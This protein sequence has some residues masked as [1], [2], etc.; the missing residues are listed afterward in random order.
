MFRLK[1]SLTHAILICVLIGAAH[2]LVD[3]HLSGE[4]EARAESSLRRA[5]VIADQTKRTDH[6]A[7]MEKG[8]MVAQD[9][10][11]YDFL[12]LERKKLLKR[13]R[14]QYSFILS[15]DVG[16]KLGKDKEKTV[17]LKGDVGLSTKDLRHLT[18]DFRLRV[19]RKRFGNIQSEMSETAR[20][21]DLD[22]LKRRPVQP[23]MLM[24]LNSSGVAVAA[25]GKDLYH[26]GAS[27]YS[28][29]VTKDHPIVQKVLDNPGAG[30]RLDVWEWSWTSDGDKS[31]YQVAIV[32]IRPSDAKKP[33]GVVVVGYTIHDGAAEDIQRLVGGVTTKKGKQNQYVDKEQVESAPDVAFFRG[34][35]IHSST[36][37]SSRNQKLE[38][39][40]FK[41]KSL[42]EK[43]DRDPEKMVNF[44]VDGT[45]YAGFVRFLPE[46]DGAETRT[47][48]MV[49][50]NMEEV[51]APLAKVLRQFDM[52][53][54][55]VFLLPVHQTGLRNRRDDRGDPQR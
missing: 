36:F 47:G 7:L 17:N 25:R 10:E 20:N 50:A 27:K 31:L 48:V 4:I 49:L 55:A 6:F 32:P 22:L 43:S 14:D 9:A 34:N 35:S 12:T 24:A 52:I 40:L 13:I 41:D 21:L 8:R 23:D 28:P 53:A 54:F 37:D 16:K 19:A 42:H 18:V 46:A 39:K 26:W 33:A 44:E 5:A 11:T 51:Q 1:I 45:P 2:L 15:S 30:P 3:M 38:K 29:D